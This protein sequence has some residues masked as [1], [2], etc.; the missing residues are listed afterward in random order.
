MR[1]RDFD[2]V[3]DAD[4]PPLENVVVRI[5]DV[6]GT[7][8]TLNTDAAG[9]A[10]LA[11][12]DN[13]LVGGRYRVQVVNPNSGT[14]SEA[15]IT[16]GHTE[17]EFA[18]AVSF[19][20]VGGG[21]DVAISVGYVD[22]TVLGIDGAR[23]FSAIQPDD[24]WLPDDATPEVYS[25]DYALDG[26]VTPLTTRS[27]LGALYG[28]G[29]DT[30]RHEIYAGA[31]AKRGSLYGPG[32]PGAIYRVDT[33]TGAW[34]QYVTVADAGDTVHD[35]GPLDSDEG[36]IH[37]DFDFRTAVGRES[38]GDVEVT[39]DNRFLTAVNM[40]TDSLVVYPVQAGVDPAPLQTLAVVAPAP[41]A[42][43]WAPMA[44]AEQGANL[45]V[46]AICGA[47]L[48]TYVIEYVRAA[49]GT[50][51]PTGT[52]RQGNVGD[53][54]PRAGQ[55]GPAGPALL[56]AD[57]RAVDWRP[58]TDTV[59]QSCVDAAVTT[60]VRPPGGRQFVVPQPMFGDLEFIDDGVLALSFRD[61]GG[62]SYGASLY[63][64][65]QTD[66]DPAYAVLIATGDLVAVSATG[67]DL[68]FVDPL[69]DFDDQG[70]VHNQAAYSGITSVP[71][72][73]T[74]VSNHMDADNSTWNNGLRS[75]DNEGG[76][77]NGIP[78][79][80]EFGKSMGLADL[81]A[82]VIEATQQI[83][84]RVWLDLDQDGVQGPDEPAIAGVQ[85]SLYDTDGNLV[86]TTETDVNGEYY[87]H[88]DDGLLPDTD[89]QI[90]LDREADYLPGG[91]LAGYSPTVADA[92]SDED[93]DS[94][95]VPAADDSGLPPYVV[96]ADITT[97]DEG[98]N[99]HSI[100]FGFVPALVSIGNYVWVDTDRDGVQDAG[101]PPV[102]GATVRLLDPD[103]NEVAVTTTDANGYYVFTDLPV[104]T[105]FIVEFPTT[106]EVG[107]Q[108]H[109]LTQPNQGD[110]A[111]DSDADPA[112]GRVSITTPATG[113]NSEVPGEADDP[114]IDAG[115]VA[116]SVS[117]G[118]FV[119]VDTDRDGIQDS[120]EPGIPGVVLVL[121]GP[122][123]GPVVDVFGNPVGPVTT[124]ADGR[125]LFPNL[126]AGVAYTVTIDQ[127]ASA[128]ALAPYVPTTAGAGSNPARDSS[129]GSATSAV[130]PNNGDHD[131]TLDFGFVLP[132]TQPPTTPAPTPPVTPPVTPTPTTVPLAG[133]LPG[134]G[135][136]VT[137]MLGLT[138]LM[139]TLGG[140]I[141]F[142]ARRGRGVA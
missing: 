81:E 6:D 21:A 123:G 135:G 68:D 89:Y 9:V 71:G 97:P 23:I 72:S 59:P 99:D 34:E 74:I 44:L 108:T 88:T 40:H 46:G 75:F 58:W 83:G 101:E 10:T 19:V 136:Q 26:P 2:N 98:I 130:L 116:P 62:D 66:G 63:I 134:T 142:A 132:E 104:S 140:I 22:H 37:H 105:D 7:T 47:D 30:D 91:P 35:I 137:K 84:N 113:N 15:Q 125:Y 33:A 100:D 13:T 3:R 107:G 42:S 41:C 131:P 139:L 39:D 87:F 54:T 112:T 27:T 5:S 90:R 92:G 80:A 126:P 76:Y 20:D 118:D 93:I 38:L 64:G 121:T 124:D 60:P 55:S 79:T 50:L 45:Y 141:T 115:F 57:C 138:L 110:D 86:A 4:D 12:A 102:P 109:V 94:E 18:P 29:L 117:V 43:D 73:G 127:A 8:I 32:G 111:I 106:I 56:H 65:E 128:A 69:Y 67:T 24:V 36:L 28:I 95:G 96:M 70:N 52:V 11:P 25:I 120:G 103:G 51:S 17:P 114:T 122:D 16:P 85:V 133:E 31:Y 49:D 14:Y 119:W 61:R 129:T 77:D 53:T 82:L 48:E 78:V 1:D